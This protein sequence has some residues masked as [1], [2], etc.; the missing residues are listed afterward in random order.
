VSLCLVLH[1]FS[2]Y[3]LQARAKREAEEKALLAEKRQWQLEGRRDAKL[4]QEEEQKKLD[5][6]KLEED[7]L[8][9]ETFR[10]VIVM[11]GL[12]LVSYCFWEVRSYIYIVVS[13][14][15]RCAG[16]IEANGRGTSHI[17]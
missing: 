16:E 1:K 14:N 11:C 5:D 12:L 17:S 13:C 9:S 10:M 3:N 7:R 15:E 8:K 4:K 6:R 2:R